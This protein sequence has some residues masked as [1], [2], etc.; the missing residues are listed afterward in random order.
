MSIKQSFQNACSTVAAIVLTPAM[1]VVAVV[2]WVKIGL[3][4][5]KE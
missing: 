2:L 3:F 1:L 4:G 5:P